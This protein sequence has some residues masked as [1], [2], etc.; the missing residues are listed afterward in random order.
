MSQQIYNW[1]RFWSHPTGT[2]SLNDGGYLDDP[3]P[4]S[5]QGR[6]RIC[7]PDVV[8]LDQI[9]EIPCLILLGEPGIGK[10]QEMQNLVKLTKKNLNLSN[11]TLERNLRS[12]SLADL[13][14]EQ[15]F[16]D[17]IN[18]SH[19]LYLFLDSLDEG[20]LEIRNLATQLVDEFGNG[21]YNGKL[22]RL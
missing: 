14:Q 5:E 1:K 13:I 7:N 11:L 6:S 3:D 10:S 17:W 9:A 22:D 8:T 15:A 4:D 21:K 19:R 12:C 2:I 18:G 16:I 20:L